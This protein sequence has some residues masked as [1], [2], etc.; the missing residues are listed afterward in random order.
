M[1]HLF[2]QEYPRREALT[3]EGLNLDL[4]VEKALE[5]ILNKWAEDGYSIREIA[6]VVAEKMT[7]MVARKIIQLRRAHPNGWEQKNE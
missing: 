2:R 7:M 6:T 3:Q 1:K 5:P 4:E